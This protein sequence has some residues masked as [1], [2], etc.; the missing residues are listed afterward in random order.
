MDVADDAARVH[1]LR[2]G[3]CSG[4]RVRCVTRIP[5]GPIVVESGRQEIAV[6]RRLAHRIKIRHVTAADIRN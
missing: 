6:G 4:S 1:A 3:M 2:F 5:A